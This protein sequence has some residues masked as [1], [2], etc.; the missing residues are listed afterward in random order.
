MIVYVRIS[1]EGGRFASKQLDLSARGA[2]PLE[3]RLGQ[4]RAVV[5]VPEAIEDFF[6]YEVFRGPDSIAH[7]TEAIIN[8][9]ELNNFN[10]PL[11][12]GA[13]LQIKVTRTEG[14]EG[15]ESVP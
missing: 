14:E 5:E 12:G 15:F 7:G 1:S 6:S 3:V 4:Y 9:G 10:V 2:N 11:P 13:V 8:N